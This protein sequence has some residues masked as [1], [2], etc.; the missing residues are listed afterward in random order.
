MQYFILITRMQKGPF[1]SE[2]IDFR[3]GFARTFQS[4]NRCKWANMILFKSSFLRHSCVTHTLEKQ[5]HPRAPSKQRKP[6]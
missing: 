4:H 1:K 5:E 2:K 3:I 6:D